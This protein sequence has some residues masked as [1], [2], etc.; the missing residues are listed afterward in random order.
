M[1][2]QDW[3]PVDFRLRHLLDSRCGHH[4]YERVKADLVRYAVAV[5]QDALAGHWGLQRNPDRAAE[6]RLA[7]SGGRVDSCPLGRRIHM[8][9]WPK[10][11][12]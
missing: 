10:E 1:P 11:D 9:G 5:Y 3:W 8:H 2:A 7:I 6:V 4:R 12:D